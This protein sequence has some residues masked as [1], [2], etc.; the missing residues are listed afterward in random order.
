MAGTSHGEHANYAFE[1]LN[2][3]MMKG[4]GRCDNTHAPTMKKIK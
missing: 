3:G 2:E 1:I 4:K